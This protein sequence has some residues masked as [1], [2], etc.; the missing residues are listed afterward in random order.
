MMNN[1]NN[2]PDNKSGEKNTDFG[3]VLAVA[4]KSQNYSIDDVCVQLKIPARII[5]AI[6]NND[7]TALPEP[8]FTQGYIRSYARFLEISEENVLAIYNQAVPH[9]RST[10]LKPRSNLPN[11][12]SSRSPLMKAVTLLLIAVGVTAAIYG[13]FQYYQEKAEAMK[14]EREAEQDSKEHSFTGN[15]LDSPGD[16]SLNVRPLNIPPMNIQPMNVLQQTRLSKNGELIVEQPAAT[17]KAEIMQMPAIDEPMKNIVTADTIAANN[18]EAAAEVVDETLASVPDEAISEEGQQSVSGIDVLKIYA[19]QGSWMEVHDASTAR[20]FYNMIPRGGEKTLQ[21]QAPFRIS[22]G[23]AKTTE[24]VINDI[25][26][27]MSK[28]IRKNNTARFTV[29]TKQQRVIFH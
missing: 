29:S 6:E 12:A 19:E 4:R 10:K 26:I 14:T 7:I 9:D 28:Y 25:V 27:D 16:N 3:S 20:L 17:E 24:L 2:E 1:S 22:L 11:E 5:I 18:A 23:N 13:G 8:T 21:G 15:S